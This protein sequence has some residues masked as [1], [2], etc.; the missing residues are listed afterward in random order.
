VGSF[1]LL[2]EQTFA[3]GRTLLAAFVGR[4]LQALP[5]LA[6]FGHHK[7][8]YWLQKTLL[9][10]AGLNHVMGMTA[11]GRR[12]VTGRDDINLVWPACPTRCFSV[13]DFSTGWACVSR[14]A[15]WMMSVCMIMIQH[16]HFHSK[17]LADM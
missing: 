11:A 17:W 10:E 8:H 5:V 6:A 15:C 13:L 9:L 2:V 4:R 1:V 3:A 16:Q 7:H 14:H 12:P